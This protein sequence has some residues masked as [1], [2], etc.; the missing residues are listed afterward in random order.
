MV[1]FSYFFPIFL[2]LLIFNVGLERAPD[3]RPSSPAGLASDFPAPGREF[4]RKTVKAIFVQ[5]G[6]E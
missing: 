6:H 1:I 4:R 3:G 5:F 2:A